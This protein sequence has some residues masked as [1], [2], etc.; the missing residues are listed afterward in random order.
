M[1]CR[2]SVSVLD[3]DIALVV[4]FVL[5][6]CLQRLAKRLSHSYGAH[7][8]AADA[9]IK[10]SISGWARYK[11]ADSIVLHFADDFG[12]QAFHLFVVVE[13][14]VEL[15]EFGSRVGDLAQPGNAG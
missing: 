2:C 9:T 12:G 15:D 11:K 4:P 14:Q 7:T 8:Q 10:S 5:P 3:D 13:E 1:P 6:M